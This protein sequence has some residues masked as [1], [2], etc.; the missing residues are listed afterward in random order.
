MENSLKQRIVG[1]IVLIALGVIFLPVILKEKTEREPF[2][3]QIPA[4]PISLVERKV[5]EQAKIQNTEMNKKLDKVEAEARKS[6]TKDTI[7]PSIEQTA[8]N[9][10][11]TDTKAADS[12]KASE[13]A[14][15]T[16][17][18]TIGKNFTD[19]AWVI[20]VASFSSMDNA[21]KL[22]SNLKSAGHKAYRRDGKNKQ[23]RVIH[24]IYVGPYIDKSRANNQLGAV[25]KISQSKA[26]LLAY[27][28]TKH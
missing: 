16:T 12:A 10:A 25:S 2:E 8:E 5:D 20:Q 4:K 23:G 11:E 13:I 28:P 17:P 22:V 1:A 27:D 9:L 26:I 6:K 21:K 19:A 18:Q 14:P 15:D 7:K 24:R 3:T